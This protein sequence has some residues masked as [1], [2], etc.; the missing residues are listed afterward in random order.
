[1]RETGASFA[2]IADALTA[3]EIPTA[4]GGRAGTGR[5]CTPSR[6]HTRPASTGHRGPVGPF[7]QNPG[8]QFIINNI[9]GSSNW[10]SIIALTGAVLAAIIAPWLTTYLARGR[11]ADRWFWQEQ[12]EAYKPLLRLVNWYLEKRSAKPMPGSVES[13]LRTLPEQP[14]VAEEDV[15]ANLLLFGSEEMRTAW[16]HYRSLCDEWREEQP[17]PGAWQAR[18]VFNASLGAPSDDLQVRLTEA[19]DEIL[20][21]AGVDARSRPKRRP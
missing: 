16:E 14:E 15:S 13:A 9:P 8:V 3:D 1:M 12:M 21:V 19:H 6:S 17:S 20:R 2:K 4:Q 10:P 7:G 18:S 11:E 5:P